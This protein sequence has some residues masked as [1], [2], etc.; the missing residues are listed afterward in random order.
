MP[1]ASVVKF[2]TVSRSVRC[3]ISRWI[4]AQF[5]LQELRR[6]DD[7]ALR[8]IG[9]TRGDIHRTATLPETECRK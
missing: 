8:D 3:F 1:A 2:V 6:L 9:I 7:A 5:A 4:R